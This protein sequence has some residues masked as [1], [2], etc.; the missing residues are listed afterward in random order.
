MPEIPFNSLIGKTLTSVVGE[1]GGESIVFTDSDGKTYTLYHDQD[2]CERVRV[3][4]INGELSDL[5]GSPVLVAEENSN[6]NENPP[7]IKPPEYQDSFTWT[8]YR[9][10]T[11]K[12]FVVIRWYGESNGYYSESVNFVEN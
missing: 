6:R 9:I 3:E 7:G 12:G 8:F 10:A 5:V 11:Q 2:C 4:D 1:V